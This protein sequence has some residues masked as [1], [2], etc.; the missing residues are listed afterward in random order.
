MLENIQELQQACE[1]IFLYPR[2]WLAEIISSDE[3]RRRLK[4]FWKKIISHFLHRPKISWTWLKYDY[5]FHPLSE[6]VICLAAVITLA[7]R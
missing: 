1:I 3:R 7:W 5:G 6:I 4:W 2:V